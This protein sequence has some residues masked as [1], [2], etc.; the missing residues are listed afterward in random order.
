MKVAKAKVPA[1][2]LVELIETH[3]IAETAKRLGVGERNVY[4]RRAR[5]EKVLGRQITAPGHPNIT[6]R[7]KI[8]H[9]HRIQLDIGEGIVLVGSDAHYWPDIISPAHRAFV[10]FCKEMKPRAVI[11]NGSN[12]N[13]AS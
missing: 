1:S 7:F 10:K 9:R 2:V 8:S 3:G 12:G 13:E 11:K 6:T 5:L 4:D